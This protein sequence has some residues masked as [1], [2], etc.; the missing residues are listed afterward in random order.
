MYVLVVCMS[1]CYMCKRLS[2]AADETETKR[3]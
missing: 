2:I 3:N 1:E